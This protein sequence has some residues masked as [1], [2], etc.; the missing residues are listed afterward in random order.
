LA[1]FSVSGLV[2][3]IDYETM[4]TQLMDLQRQPVTRMQSQQSAYNKTISVY[5]DLTAKLSA[6]KTSAE[7]LKTPANFYS[8]KA[9]A[10][11][12]TIFEA[13]AS[14]SAAAGNYTITVTALA[15]A[16]RMASDPVS[17]ATDVIAAGAGN[18]SFQV[19]AGDVTTVAVDATTTLSNLRDAINAA[20]GD[21]EASI[22]ND[23][24]GYRLVLTSRDSGE[25]NGITVI[26]N[27]TTLGLPSGPVTG[28]MELQAAQN[29]EFSIDTLPMTW[30][31]NDITD[32]IGGIAITLKK[33]GTATLSVTN[34]TSA[35]RQKV[36]DFVSAY[37]D[38][39]TLVSSNATYDTTTNAGGP[40][41]GEATARDVVNR[42]QSI[43]GSRIDGLPEGLRA[44]SQ[45]G[46]KTGRDGT[47]SI[48]DTALSDKLTTDL[49]AVSDL[50]TVEGGVAS[51]VSDYADEATD[52]LT[53]SI[54]YRTKGLGTIVSGIDDDISRLDARLSKQEED[55]RAQFARLESLLASLSSQSSYLTSL[56]G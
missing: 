56:L 26:E 55:L 13:S 38:V 2:S 30:S 17:A 54:A 1:T 23:G 49:R 6:L 51:A 43:I 52:S 37:N 10:S 19:G 44:L 53:G 42:L 33:E 21:A 29:A 32:A 14:S 46:I 28:G 12:E 15:Q 4:I 11:D 22:I 5:G 3:G 8:R 50:F 27:S 16:H 34:D 31:G 7:G 47:L 36:E 24:T 35:I 45:I 18:F 20:E 48:D 40:L 41:T 39:V 25:D 9:T